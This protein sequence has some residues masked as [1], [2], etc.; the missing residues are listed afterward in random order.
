MSEH[1][2]QELDNAAEAPAADD[3][4]ESKEGLDGSLFGTEAELYFEPEGLDAV[5]RSGKVVW[6]V[7]KLDLGSGLN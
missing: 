1:A 3:P 2:D 6:S 7:R 4:L 5:R